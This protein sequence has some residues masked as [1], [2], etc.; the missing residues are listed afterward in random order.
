MY[1]IGGCIASPMSCNNGFKSFPSNGIGHTRS[2]G[3]DVSKVNN[4]NPKLSNPSTPRTLT[5]KISGKV[6]LKQATLIVQQDKMS[7]HNNNEP[8]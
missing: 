2:N 1:N 8:S 6:L 7:I 5:E 3:L 4:K